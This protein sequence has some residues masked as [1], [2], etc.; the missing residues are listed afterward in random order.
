MT[1][2]K[3]GMLNRKIGAQTWNSKFGFPNLKIG[4]FQVWAQHIPYKYD[5]KVYEIIGVLHN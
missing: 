3:F 4:R 5:S 1:D 2:S